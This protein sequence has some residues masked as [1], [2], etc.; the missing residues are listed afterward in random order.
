MSG[1][2][3]RCWCFDLRQGSLVVAMTLLLLY[4]LSSVAL[5]VDLSHDLYHR[6]RELL[7]CEI[8]LLSALLAQL[9]AAGFLARA[10][11]AANRRLLLGWLL[12][13]ASCWL[14]TLLAAVS[15]VTAAA[16]MMPASPAW[17]AAG[18]GVA[19]LLLTLL[20]YMWTV[21][22]RFY[23]ITETKVLDA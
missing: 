2:G 20:A 14:L 8:T 6:P 13:H 4:G 22:L 15:G 11:A 9:V 3:N 19:T 1:S 7:I 17:P 16:L 10:A 21:V 12:W 5:V 23:Q 18:G